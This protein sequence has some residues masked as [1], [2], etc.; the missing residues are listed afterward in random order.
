MV[1]KSSIFVDIDVKKAIATL[2]ELDRTGTKT[3]DSL[4]KG[5]NK[6]KM[7]ADQLTGSLEK[8]SKGA[9]AGAVGF[10]T[11]SMG[12]LNL[13]TSAV[14]TYTSLSNLDRVQNRAAASAVGLERANDLL[15]RKTMQ[16]TKLQEAGNGAGRDAA[17]IQKEIATA[18]MDLAVKT[19]KLKIEQAAV[20]DVYLLFFANIANVGVSTMMVM[21]N[22]M[23]KEQIARVKSIA[24]TKLHT[25]STWENLKASRASTV[26]NLT[27]VGGL[28]AQGSAVTR[29]TIKTKLLTAA[30]NGYKLALGP[31]GLIL[32]GITAVMGLFMASTAGAE[33]ETA[34]LTSS[35]DELLKSFGSSN[36][37]IGQ[38]TKLLFDLPNK[39]KIT[40]NDVDALN[41][42]YREGAADINAWNKAAKEINV[43]RAQDFNGAVGD[44]GNQNSGNG[45][46][47]FNT[48]RDINNRIT[49][50]TSNISS[51][52]IISG[53]SG[54]NADSTMKIIPNVGPW[55]SYAYDMEGY[56]VGSPEEMRF[57]SGELKT[58]RWIDKFTR[59]LDN[60]IQGAQKPFKPL[61]DAMF[62]SVKWE[63]GK[64]GKEEDKKD[65]LRTLGK[66]IEKETEWWNEGLWWGGYESL[67]QKNLMINGKKDIQI[68]GN[69]ILSAKRKESYFKVVADNPH[70][71]DPSIIMSLFKELP[72]P[73]GGEG[74]FIGYRFL[75]KI[76]NTIMGSEHLKESVKMLNN[77][78]T[79]M[80]DWS[81]E[82][83]TGLQVLVDIALTTEEG[84]R[85]IVQNDISMIGLDSTKMYTPETW[86]EFKKE[87][88]A[89]RD[90]KDMW[91]IEMKMTKDTEDQRLQLI[92]SQFGYNDKGELN[93]SVKDIMRREKLG[94][95]AGD[96]LKYVNKTLTDKQ[97]E[98][99]EGYGGIV[100][101][102]GNRIY[103][104]TKALDAMKIRKRL[105]LGNTEQFLGSEGKMIGGITGD[106]VFDKILRETYMQNYSADGLMYNSGGVS[107]IYNK[108]ELEFIAEYDDWGDNRKAA[109]DK[110]GLDVGKSAEVMNKDDVMRLALTQTIISSFAGSTGGRTAILLASIRSRGG[111]NANGQIS[112]TQAFQTARGPGISRAA[113]TENAFQDWMSNSGTRNIAIGAG[114][115]FGDVQK[116]GMG[117][118][119]AIAT[120]QNFQQME[121][122]KNMARQFGA[123]AI[124]QEGMVAALQTYQNAIDSGDY[125]RTRGAA[126][127]Y[128]QA[129][130][131]IAAANNARAA[132]KAVDIG[133]DFNPNANA[134]YWEWYIVGK[135]IRRSRWITTSP[136]SAEQIRLD[137]QAST[138][139]SLP[140]AARITAIS[141]SFANNGNFT[142]FNNTAIT[143]DAMVKLGMTEQKVFDIRFESTR[144]DRE[145]ENRMRHVEQRAAS[146]SGL[147]PL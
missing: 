45:G 126:V 119:G 114:N 27:S 109:F 79:M 32:I 130:N 102:G 62:T 97:M 76:P 68:A 100:N 58:A 113:Q 99:L 98:I 1:V 66:Q 128:Y 69:K 67:E 56:D 116:L 89:A 48:V 137:I 38:Q 40:K 108:E 85:A 134:G 29:L 49:Q 10:Q 115:V 88:K 144:G 87:E 14:Q 53:D 131:S 92:A 143:Q 103:T 124:A 75:S 81:E 20:T 35:N 41:K 44:G 110:Y 138:S 64:D 55:G 50:Q 71:Y 73:A 51:D 146:S 28:E 74:R 34:K 122:T 139:V 39:L 136:S 24:T 36:D 112:A 61:Y 6:A 18:T 96:I 43:K 101:I 23:S 25:L 31:I 4:T 94:G 21:S 37:V 95:M 123:D 84:A 135:G 82:E 54:A 93:V 133:I 83:I 147:S 12:M 80:T 5:A 46:I 141:Q 17:L 3:T 60:T 72:A 57:N 121:V 65:W 16:L 91:D 129:T 2:N 30:T 86:T 77:Q 63:F 106:T 26:V 107:R 105:E 145:L 104:P 125:G 19:E 117:Y 59:G 90:Y 7:A 9:T 13:S 22:M 111:I 140:S 78:D 42:S 15:A 142:N 33:E 11:M 127:A 8:G 70:V 47:N 52:F 118:R 132:A 120:P